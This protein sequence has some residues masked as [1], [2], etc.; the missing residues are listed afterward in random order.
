MKKALKCAL[1]KEQIEY[2]NTLDFIDGYE[3]H[4]YGDERDDFSLAKQ[5]NK[6]IYSVHYALDRCDIMDIAKEFRSDYA[7]SVFRLCK[8]LNVGLVV[9]AESKY[10]EIMASKDVDAFCD[11]IKDNDITLHVENCYRDI[12]A[13]ES[14]QIRRYIR[15]RVGLDKVYSL[16]DTCHLMMSEMS[17][18]YD[19]LSFSEAIDRFK[20]DNYI[21]HLNDCIGSGEK[22]TGG[23]HGTNFHYN[24]Y[25]LNNILW[26]LYCLEKDGYFAKL[27]LECDEDDFIHNPNAV[28]LAH[29]IDKFWNSYTDE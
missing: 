4:L 29:N 11:F 12:G 24:M 16:L 14:I 3:I 9:H 7:Q 5:M 22:E 10:Y 13:I 2:K 28:E 15:A 6:D 17:F 23:I 1:E 26:R 20:S 25:L 18:K 21:I 19:E 8:E 27:V